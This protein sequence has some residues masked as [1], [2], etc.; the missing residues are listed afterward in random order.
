MTE[1]DGLVRDPLVI[2]IEHLPN[3]KARGLLRLVG[4]MQSLHDCMHILCAPCGS[5]LLHNFN[6]LLEEQLSH[7]TKI[8]PL[9]LSQARLTEGMGQL[10]GL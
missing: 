9:C 7:G 5:A 6:C 1:W 3:L 4:L 10:P 8:E 2:E